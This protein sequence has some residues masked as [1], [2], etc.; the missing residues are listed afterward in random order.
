MAYTTIDNPGEYFNTVLY[1][2][3]GSTSHAIRGVGFQP[4]W[5]WVKERGGANS[6]ML[7][8]SVRGATNIIFSNLNNVEDTGDTGSI[9]AFGSDGFTVGN[10]GNVNANNDTYVGWNWKAGTAFSN[11]ASST[12]VGSID[13]TG[14]VN[15]DAGFSI[16]KYTGN[17][18]NAATIAHGLGA[19]PKMILLKSLGETDDWKVYHVSRGAT[20]WLKFNESGSG[21]TSSTNF[22]DT[23][24]TS[25]VYSVGSSTGTNNTN[26]Q[27]AYC[28]QRLRVQQVWI[29]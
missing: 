26:G 29:I 25:S 10:S 3:N 16:I 12:G 20:K 15:T 6:H 9:T 17:E 22:N 14:S 11:D 5:V 4:D 18:P 2:G 19:V 24:P 21:G 7:A 23:E 13:S 27:I 28:L 1:T 8:D